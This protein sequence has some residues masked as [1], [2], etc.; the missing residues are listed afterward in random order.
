M[1]RSGVN[2]D[3]GAPSATSTELLRRARANN[4]D[5][6]D[7]LVGRYSRRMYRWCRR[8]GLQPDDASNVVQEA[9]TSVA[10][11]LP[12]FRRDRPSDTFRGWLRRITDNKIRDF[13]RRQGRTLAVAVGGTDAQQQLA[14]LT[15]PNREDG[16]TWDTSLADHPPQNEQLEVAIDQVRQNVSDRDWRFFWR[17]VVDGQ[18][19]AEVADEFGVSANA[20]RLVKMRVLRKLRHTI[21]IAESQN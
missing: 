17:V 7:E 12:D 13:Y 4:Q 21:E 8:A 2:P 5:A 11:K 18:S 10:R 14:Q 19:A 1:K 20:V 15:G 9:L 6:W 16:A 3:E